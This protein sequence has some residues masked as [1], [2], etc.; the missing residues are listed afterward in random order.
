MPDFILTLFYQNLQ[1][2]SGDGDKGT[3]FRVNVRAE[4]SSSILDFI[5]STDISA[6]MIVRGMKRREVRMMKLEN[7]AIYSKYLLL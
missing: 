7:Y 1:S 2:L 5:E 4:L 6:D 3:G